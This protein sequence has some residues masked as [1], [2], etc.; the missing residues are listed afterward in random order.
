[1]KHRRRIDKDVVQIQVDCPRW[2]RKR[3]LAN[4]A[5]AV[6][7]RVNLERAGIA[8]AILET[9]KAEPQAAEGIPKTHGEKLKV[10]VPQLAQPAIRT[11]RSKI[12]Q[13][14]RAGFC[15]LANH[16]SALLPGK[17]LLRPAH[18]RV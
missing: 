14:A 17:R 7:D 8:R 9:T 15:K 3:M 2:I 11:A 1:M 12:W 16:I 6:R 4:L 10:I 5:V 13:S 18:Q